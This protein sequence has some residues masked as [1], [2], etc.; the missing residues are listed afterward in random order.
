MKVILMT[1]LVRYQQTVI[2]AIIA[3]MMSIESIFLKKRLA[4][5]M[6]QVCHW[7]LKVLMAID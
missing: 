6:F 7:Q 1:M 4:T 5:Q 2:L 3:M